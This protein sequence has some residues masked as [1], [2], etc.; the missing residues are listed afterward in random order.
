MI[1]KC[2]ETLKKFLD[3]KIKIRFMRLSWSSLKDIKFVLEKLNLIE[4]YPDYIL[5]IKN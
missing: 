4:I 1:I 3:D 2:N 5:K